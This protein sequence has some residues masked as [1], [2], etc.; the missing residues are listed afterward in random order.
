MSEPI[1]VSAEYIGEYKILVSFKDGLS[2]T[3]DLSDSLWGPVFEPLKDFSFFKSFSYNPELN[4][5]SWPN[6][7]DIAPESLYANVS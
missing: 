5:I 3:V 1:L 2:G 6:G 7:A 4:T